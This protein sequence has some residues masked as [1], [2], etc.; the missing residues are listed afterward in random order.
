[1]SG[2]NDDL[3]QEE[4]NSQGE[5]EQHQQQHGIRDDGYR[6]AYTVKAPNATKRAQMEQARA[7]DY[8]TAQQAERLRQERIEVSKQAIRQATPSV[9]TLGGAG[10]STSGT[11]DEERRKR[12]LAA[13]RRESEKLRT[14]LA[15]EEQE[16]REKEVQEQRDQEE[17]RRRQNAARDRN[18][19]NERAQVQQAQDAVRQRWENHNERE[20]QRAVPPAIPAAA[21]PMQAPPRPE[22]LQQTQPQFVAAAARDV[23]NT[24]PHGDRQRVVS[25]QARE[26]IAE[27]IQWIQLDPFS[28][29]AAWISVRD[30]VASLAGGAPLDVRA[31]RNQLAMRIAADRISEIV[32]LLFTNAHDP[33]GEG[34]YLVPEN[35]AHL[36]VVA[37]MLG[38]IIAMSTPQYAEVDDPQP[39]PA[40]LPEQRPRQQGWH[41]PNVEVERMRREREEQDAAYEL[42]SANDRAKEAA[43][44]EKD[45]EDARAMRD[46]EAARIAIER[47]I[48]LAATR[49]L[50]EPP[51]DAPDAFLVRFRLPNGNQSDRRFSDHQRVSAL[52]DFV[53][54]ERMV[55]ASHMSMFELYINNMMRI[56]NAREDTRIL[57]DM[58]VTGGGMYLIHVRW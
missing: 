27:A 32:A 6:G 46:A 52:H 51:R 18:V 35:T 17:R 37:E 53:V 26:Q 42:S 14:K 15:K 38:D 43:K 4:Q 20:Q 3:P 55:D 19:A 28:D 50:P 39:P 8:E 49:M 9:A 45:M 36:D 30:A 10:T 29:L 57:G 34:H 25:T 44:H 5:N 1:M 33:T 21:P 7:R 41:E 31:L 12:L 47:Q 48:N 24:A 40:P 58:G 16:R 22:P 23:Q 54:A 11:Q 13:N 2:N 56:E